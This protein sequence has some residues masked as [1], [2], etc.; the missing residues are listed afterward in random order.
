MKTSFFKISNLTVALFIT[1]LAPAFAETASPITTGDFVPN[2]DGTVTHKPSGLMWQACSVGQT[3]NAQ[4]GICTGKVAY[5]NHADA[6]ALALANDF[7]GHTD[8]RIPSIAELRT[9]MNPRRVNPAIDSILFPNTLSDWYRAVTILGWDHNYTW[10]VHFGSGENKW[11]HIGNG[12]AVRLV[13]GNASFS[14]NK[15]TDFVDHSDGTITHNKTGLTWQR[16]SMGQTWLNN[17][18]CEGTATGYTQADAAKLSSELAGQKDW[19]LPTQKELQT[20]LNYSTYTPAIDSTIFPDTPSTLFWTTTSAKSDSKAK[21]FVNF[22]NGNTSYTGSVSELYQARLVRGTQLTT[23]PD[24]VDLNT[25]LTVNPSP[26]KLNESL[27]FSATV[28]NKGAIAAT[29]TILTF[30]LA[31]KAMTFVAAE[32][33]TAKTLSVVCTLGDLAP[34]ASVTRTM[35]VKAIKAGGVSSTA[36]AKASEVDINAAD[37]VGRAVLAIKK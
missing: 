29:G 19:R 9:I 16:C 8:W 4:F 20:I 2:G 31:P 5:P 15:T 27:T 24:T 37:N 3:W 11:V 25:A 35:T 21:W 14:T 18:I 33:C 30:Y 7:A 22:D 6:M 1:V 23:Y 13:R 36:L 12:H 32:G 34:N 10:S 17:N 28:T 26:A